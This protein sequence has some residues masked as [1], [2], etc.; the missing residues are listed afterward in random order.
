MKKSK[1]FSGALILTGAI[2]LAA[3]IGLSL[4]RS[5]REAKQRETLSE[6]VQK[7]QEL[8]SE[9]AAGVPDGRSGEDMPRLEIGGRDYIGLLELPERG[10]ALPVAADR[11]TGLF[12]FQPARYSGTLYGGTL[13]VG[14]SCSDGCFAFI[15]Q[16]DAGDRVNFTDVQGVRYAFAVSRITHNATI[17]I[18]GSRS[19]ETP[20]LLF[21]KKGSSYLAAHFVTA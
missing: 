20:L 12:S 4:L 18:D 13:F 2:L 14:G 6:A 5:W 15:A 3:A 7:M 19:P 9:P 8:L 21:T 1:T 10:V 16:L 17:D 11:D